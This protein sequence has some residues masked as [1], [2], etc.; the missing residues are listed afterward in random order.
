MITYELI[1]SD[2]KTISLQVKPDG[3]VIVRAPQRLA[4][5]RVVRFVKDHE[6]WILKQQKKL[7][8]YRETRHVITDE[9]RRDGV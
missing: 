9:E 6:D 5:Y 4:K 8:D 3:R 7:E 1:R 2:R